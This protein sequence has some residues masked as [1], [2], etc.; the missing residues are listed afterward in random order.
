MKVNIADPPI[1]VRLLNRKKR[2]KKITYKLDLGT[3][4]IDVLTWANRFVPSESG[5]IL[6]DDPV[7]KMGP[8]GK[9]KL[10]FA[11]SFGKGSSGLAGASIS[12]NRGIAATTYRSGKPSISRDVTRDSRFYAAIDEKTGYRTRS[13]IC[14]P[15]LIGGSP[16]GVI[17]LI[18]RKGRINYDGKDLSLLN[19]FAGYTATVMH[20]ALIARNYEELSGQDNLTG[21]HNDRYFLMSLHSEIENV[22]R[23]GGDVA[24]IFFDLDYFK[25]VNDTHGHIVGSRVLKEVGDILKKVFRGTRSVLSRYGGDEYVIVMPGPGTE[26]AKK[27]AETLR[28]RIA[29][30][31]FIKRKISGRKGACNIKGLVTCSVGVASLTE[32][33]AI[34]DNSMEMVETLIK[35]ADSAMYQSKQQGKN[36]VSVAKGKLTVDRRSLCHSALISSISEP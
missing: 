13:V 21:L 24:L 2:T 36:R 32:N 23:R 14:A 9:G 20:N 31:I 10:Y 3:V 25:E 16:I 4:L 12:V 6:L 28:D 35:A 26:T 7:L 19:V 29:R 5:S 1:L 34:S 17:E 15:I 22:V 18:N 11:A 8:E 33:V 30:N 27:Y